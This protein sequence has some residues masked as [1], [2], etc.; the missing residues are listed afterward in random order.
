MKRMV[1][2]LLW[3]DLACAG[4]SRAETAASDVKAQAVVPAGDQWTALGTALATDLSGGKA[5]V[6]RE[7]QVSGRV[8][9]LEEKKKPDGA[10]SV[11]LAMESIRVLSGPGGAVCAVETLSV[12]P[13]DE[14]WAAWKNVRPGSRVTFKTTLAASTLDPRGGVVTVLTLANHSQRAWL[15]TSGATLIRV[16]AVE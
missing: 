2:M 7:V 10:N 11:R 9:E 12:L 13:S 16:D 8:T 14:E 5:W 15:S 3:A 1:V 6:G 4:W